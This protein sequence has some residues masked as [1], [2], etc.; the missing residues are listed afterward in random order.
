MKLSNSIRP[1]LGFFFAA[2]FSWLVLTQIEVVRLLSLFEE[3]QIAWLAL[4]LLCF[5]LG[6]GC[7][8]ERWRLMLKIDNNE[9]RWGHCAG[10]LL[11]SFAL[12]NI[13]PLRA[14]DI[15]RAFAF[16]RELGVSS[17]VVIAT[18]FVE[19]L[20]DM[21]VILFFLGALSFLFD[22]DNIGFLKI[23]GLALFL[24]SITL[25]TLFLSTGLMNC[26]GN[27]LIQ[28][29]KKLKF[30]MADKIANEV[31]KSLNTLS[32]LAKG[33]TMIKL[34][35]WSLAAWIFEALMFL[36]AAEAIPSI[37]HAAAAWLAFPVGTLATLI[38]SSPGYVGTFDYF[39][40]QA[41][42]LFGNSQLASAA[43]AF[44]V[45]L[46]MW[47][48]PTVLGGLYLLYRPIRNFQDIRSR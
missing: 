46:L 48:P 27:K 20:L 12:N 13:L 10:P 35:F 36:T 45:H 5:S 23:G 38:P 26:F 2:F 21:F 11:S 18:L 25:L 39:V 37:K 31:H 15:M 33:R 40:M 17:G 3:I 14:G 41:M 4:G 9:I 1:C 29:T 47:L 22:L 7:R 6:Y 30:N 44:T 43:Y 24:I 16:N 42:V 34:I 32:H 19:R 28:F 8:I